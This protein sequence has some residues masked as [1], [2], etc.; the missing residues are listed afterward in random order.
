VEDGMI[1]RIKELRKKSHEDFYIKEN[2]Y[3]TNRYYTLMLRKNGKTR[4]IFE[5][6]NAEETAGF[7]D[8]LITSFVKRSR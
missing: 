1:R 4:S 5:K 2:S 6:R 8:G 7:I 3:G